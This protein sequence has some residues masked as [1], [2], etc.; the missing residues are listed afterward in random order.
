MAE[1]PLEPCL[2]K[3]LITSADLGCS[4]EILTILAMLSVENPFY[5]LKEGSADRHEKC[6]V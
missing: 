5:R 2:F 6:Q 4:V 3:M 1:I